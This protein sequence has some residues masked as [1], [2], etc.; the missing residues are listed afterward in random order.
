MRKIKV[1]KLNNLMQTH[2]Q[3]LTDPQWEAI[4]KHLPIHRKRTYDLRDIIDGI[5]WGLRI[6]NQWRNM[7]E[8]FPPWQ[9]VYYYFRRWKG[10]ETLEKLNWAMNRL[11][12]E[13]VGKEDTPSLFCIDT[14]SVKTAPFVSHCKGVDGNKKINGRKRHIITDTVGLVWSVVVHGANQADGVM[15]QRVVDPLQGY[16]HRMKKILADAAY[17]KVFMQWVE[18]NLLGVDFEIS[19]KPPTS[20]EFVPVKWR[21]VG[22]RTFGT[23]NFFRR[24]DKDHEKTIESSEAWILWQNC[25]I[26]LNRL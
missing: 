23:F 8:Y 19:S 3:R 24:L 16:M 7:P 15:A 20:Q 11:E 13:R 25:Q 14:Q 17:E 4:K 22:E 10:D 26:I 21:W 12:R 5:F 9:S 6:G 18:E 1:T 2:Y